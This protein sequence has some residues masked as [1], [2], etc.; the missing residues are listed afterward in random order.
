MREV[1]GSLDREQH[2][3]RT[4]NDRQVLEPLNYPLKARYTLTVNNTGET[5]VDFLANA[6]TEPCLCLIP[7]LSGTPFCNGVTNPAQTLT[8]GA[9]FN[10]KVE[11]TIDTYTSTS[12]R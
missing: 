11:W 8:I 5:E 6:L 7:D 4:G 3:D 10:V 2:E 9:S 12:R 1:P